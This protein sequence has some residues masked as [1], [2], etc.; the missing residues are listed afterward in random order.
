MQQVPKQRWGR[1]RRRQIAE[2]REGRVLHLEGGSAGCPRAPGVPTR[3]PWGLAQGGP[4]QT[5]G[6]HATLGT[7]PPAPS[8]PDRRR[9]TPRASLRGRLGPALPLTARSPTAGPNGGGLTLGGSRRQRTARRGSAHPGAAR[10][11]KGRHTEPAESYVTGRRRS[12]D[13]GGGPRH[14]RLPCRARGS[15][16]KPIGRRAPWAPPPDAADAAILGEGRPAASPGRGG[17][18]SRAAAG[19]RRGSTLP[20]W[21]CVGAGGALLGGGLGLM[22]RPERRPHRR[23]GPETRL[24]HGRPVL[25]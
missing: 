17:A 16:R 25:G 13:G 12:R 6:S 5:A 10:A 4:R 23:G 20:S 11:G 8:G 7:A 14:F 3:S 21:V 1:A 22:G 24:A 9:S 18:C 19:A 15:G 2:L